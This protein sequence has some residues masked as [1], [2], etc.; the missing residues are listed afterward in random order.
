MKTKLNI[1]GLSC[2][3]CVNAVNNILNEV[4]GVTKYNV[5][6]PNVAEI[7][8]DEKIVDIELIKQEI[9][10]SEIYKVV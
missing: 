5:F 1:E 4:K 7:E 6:L 10:N 8:F 2:G 9:N 3:H